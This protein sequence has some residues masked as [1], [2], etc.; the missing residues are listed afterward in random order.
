MQDAEM[1]EN[2]R[3]ETYSGAKSKPLWIY[4]VTQ[5][6]KILGQDIQKDW[7]VS[8]VGHGGVE[9]LSAFIH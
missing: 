6:N 8:K 2:W 4:A 3:Q 9:E 1:M 5:K 7:I